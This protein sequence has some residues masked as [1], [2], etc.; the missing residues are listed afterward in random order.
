M[1]EE[2]KCA[3]TAE[4][5]RI[6]NPENTWNDEAYGTRRISGKAFGVDVF[7]G[8]ETAFSST[9]VLG[10]AFLKGYIGE[11]S[12]KLYVVSSG[13]Q[14]YCIRTAHKKGED[15]GKMDKH[16]PIYRV[17]ELLELISDRVRFQEEITKRTSK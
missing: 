14:F 3:F 8:F 5:K 17:D 13:F 10:Q 12:F 6:T 9:Y 16:I 2:I 7:A 11:L 1:S 15:Y 4:I